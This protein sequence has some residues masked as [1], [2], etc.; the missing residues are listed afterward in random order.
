MIAIFW[1]ILEEIETI[2]RSNIFNH[3]TENLVTGVAIFVEIISNM[4]NQVVNI[5]RAI[6][7]NWSTVAPVIMG[8]VTALSLYTTALLF[9]NIVNGISTAKISV[10]NAYMALEAGTTFVATAAQYGFNAALLACPITWIILG[11]IAIVASLY[12]VIEVINKVT[13]SN[14]SAMGIIC[15]TVL[16]AG[17]FIGNLFI[18]LFNGAVD[19]IGAIWEAISAFVNFFANVFNNPVEAIARL[20][21]D[22]VNTIL[23]LLKSLASA[24]DAIFGSKLASS[25][26][27]WKDKLRSVAN[28]I[29]GKRE[30]PIEIFDTSSAHLERIQYHDAWNMGNNL[31]KGFDDK[32]KSFSLQS[33]LEGGQ[34]NKA[35]YFNEVLK[36]RQENK[37][38]I[39]DYQNRCLQ[40][41]P[42][43]QYLDATTAETLGSIAADTSSIKD[44]VTVTSEE[45]AY[46]REIAEKEAVNRFTTAEIKV[47]MNN[48]NTISSNMDVDGITGRLKEGMYKA[49][50]TAREGV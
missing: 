41:L 21:F 26:Q 15:G 40:T 30:Q 24:I 19:I 11:I 16:T 42:D 39:F 13:S 4:V 32:I 8:I 22:L 3:L 50:A 35:E 45:I 29:L 17:S 46:L 28:D 37:P 6:Y 1:P 33:I 48:T 31:G 34:G 18:G 27:N 20:F 25:V 44:S 47:N 36:E 14:L 43:N 12:T 7:D 23:S 38:D 2:T 49:M 9:Y 5:G 10:M